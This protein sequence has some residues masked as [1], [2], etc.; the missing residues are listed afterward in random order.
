MSK[1]YFLNKIGKCEVKNDQRFCNCYS[2]FTGKYCQSKK[3]LETTS[4]SPPTKSVDDSTKPKI[5]DNVTQFTSTIS[6]DEKKCKKIEKESSNVF[7]IAILS[8]VV[9]L[10]LFWIGIGIYIKL[11]GKIFLNL[12]RIKKSYVERNG[13]IYSVEVLEWRDKKN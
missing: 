6:P 10:I 4:T 2:R 1:R 9:P 8:S 5:I 11:Y 12:E 7:I 13:Y 3:V